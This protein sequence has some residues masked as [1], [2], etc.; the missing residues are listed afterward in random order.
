MHGSE[1]FRCEWCSLLV[2]IPTAVTS[3]QG[4]RVRV[5]VRACVCVCPSVRGADEGLTV[6]ILR[7]IDMDVRERDCIR[8]SRSA[9]FLAP[10]A[11]GERAAEAGKKKN[12]QRASQAAT[13]P[14]FYS[15]PVF[16]FCT[17]RQI[18]P[19]QTIIKA[20]HSATLEKA[21]SHPQRGTHSAAPN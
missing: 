3:S 4:H 17:C 15:P 13:P 19:R 9:S 18:K 5:R 14:L 7:V 21:S 1:W 10:P 20:E 6:C 16:V 12:H 11:F 2:C 8:W